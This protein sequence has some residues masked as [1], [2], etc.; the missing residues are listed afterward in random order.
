MTKEEKA[1]HIKRIKEM[2]KS[3]LDDMTIFLETLAKDVET[4]QGALDNGELFDSEYLE[5]VTDM[6]NRLPSEIEFMKSIEQA[7]NGSRRNIMS[8]TDK[9]LK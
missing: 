4:L 5:Y 6:A 2:K 9:P 8:D 3:Y 7:L 1:K